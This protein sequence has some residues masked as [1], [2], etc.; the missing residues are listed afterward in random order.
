MEL[1][2]PSLI[3]IENEAIP[4]H[5]I[6]VTRTRV[7]LHDEDGKT[8]LILIDGPYEQRMGE[9]AGMGWNGAFDKLAAALT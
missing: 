6:G 7:E 4:D 3:V 5:G 1:E 9:M 2:E 8:R